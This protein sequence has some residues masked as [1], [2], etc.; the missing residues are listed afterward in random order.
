[1]KRGF[2]M[3]ILLP[4]PRGYCAGVEM[5]IASLEQA[6]EY[7]TPPLYAYHQIVHNTYLVNY[8]SG[9]GIIFVNNISDIP[10]DSIV[11]YSAHGVSPEVRDQSEN[12]NLTVIDATCPLVTKVHHEAEKFA[13]KGYQI[14]LI[15]HHGHDEVVGTTGVAQEV[16]HVVSSVN[17]AKQIE[18]HD[19]KKLV[20]LTQTTLCPDEVQSIVKV[21]SQRF[22]GITQPGKDDIC[23]ATHNRQLAVRLLAPKAQLVLVVGSKNSSN[24]QR[25]VDVA[26]SCQT[27]AYLIDSFQDIYLPWFNQ[28]NTMLLTSGASVP[29]SLVEETLHWLSEQFSCELKHC[30]IVRENMHFNLPTNLRQLNVTL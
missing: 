21:L 10:P 13:N 3:Q 19:T 28:I 12:L 6:L 11:L 9:K 18:L 5:A 1:M 7:Y 22:P 24:S 17:E 16:I 23:Y 15:G 30:D 27:P 14:I 4:T 2:N 25:L 20:Y 29:K 8:F 26:H